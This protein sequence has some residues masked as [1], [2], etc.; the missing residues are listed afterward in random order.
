MRTT[1]A[2]EGSP[3]RSRSRSVPLQ[4][5]TRLT[6]I[7]YGTEV[8]EI[9]SGRIDIQV[10]TSKWGPRS[11]SGH[12]SYVLLARHTRG[13]FGGESDL[14]GSAALFLC[15]RSPGFD[16]QSRPI[17]SQERGPT[18][19][20]AL[21]K[22]SKGGPSEMGANEIQRL[23]GQEPARPDRLTAPARSGAGNSAQSI[24]SS[25]ASRD[26]ISPGASGQM[27]EMP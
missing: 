27:S 14:S 4:S 11:G 10:T 25:A 13:P 19:S 8:G 16:V 15:F 3:G 20:P 6:R 2:W 9:S 5:D 12:E 18:H 22:L 1:S 23:L 24:S 21:L 7:S 26:S 17:G